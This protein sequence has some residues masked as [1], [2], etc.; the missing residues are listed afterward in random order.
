[1]SKE[2]TTKASLTQYK[3]IYLRLLNYALKYK[4]ILLISIICIFFQALTNTG[5]L[6]LIK[7]VTDEGFVNDSSS[8]TLFFP[9]VL[10]FLILIRAISRFISSY[11]MRW[12]SRKVV[13]DLRHQAFKRLMLL[14]VTFIDE[15]ST[16]T[17]VSKLTY[18]TELLSTIATKV[19]LDTLRD[20]LTVI[21][22]VCYMLYLDWLLTIIFGLMAP[23]MAYYLKKISP[24]LRDSAKEVQAS[25]G[26]MTS[27]SEEVISGQRIV[28]IFGSSVFELKRFLSI[29]VRNRKMQTKLARLSATN[30]F[31]V[32]ILS[33]LALAGV[34]YYSVGNLTPGEFAAF[35]GAT[36]FLITPIRRLT[37][38]NE[39]IQVG[40]SAAVSIFSIMDEKQEPN[41]GKIVLTKIKGDI[42][43]KDVCFSYPKNSKFSISNIDLKINSGEKVALVGRSGGG[44]TTLL[45]LIPRFYN[46]DSGR[47][48]IDGKDINYLKL[49]NLRHHIALVSQDTIL[50]NNSIFNNIAYGI[51]NKIDSKK[52]RQAAEAANAIEF[53]DKLPN[54][55]DHIIGDR[56]VR[57]SGGQ[58]QRIAIARAILKNA[59]ILL[60]DEA[61][62]ALDSESETLVQE[63]LD[64]LMRGK[65]SIVIAHRLSTVIN[66]DK[67]VVID[68]GKIVGVGKHKDLIK[69]NKHYSKIY[70]EGLK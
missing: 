5:F 13:E 44:K 47:I 48:S 50:F 62:S 31:I 14:P 6:A 54:G 41:T 9:L 57:L 39:Q 40:Y 33:G 59:P 12:I 19:T 63:A 69:N 8:I 29:V 61:T 21:G 68:Q 56:G 23:I 67:I 26:E 43:F 16:G 3:K 65:T 51:L 34:L 53:I 11:A 49:G 32:E 52:V 46:L 36:V 2:Q 18:E 66:A 1:M 17:L 20:A 25:M 24:K 15:H 10:I 35:V 64:N 4:L 60:L 27:T 37:A 22:V 58:K 38:I 55:F 70:K 30:G 42:E 28:K 45:N 7:K